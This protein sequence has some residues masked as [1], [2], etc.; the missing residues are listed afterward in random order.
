[1]RSIRNLQL[2]D[3]QGTIRMDKVNALSYDDMHQWTK[4]ILFAADPGGGG[5]HHDLPHGFLRRIYGQL[6]PNVRSVF[7]DTLRQHLV[8]MATNPESDWRGDAADELLLLVGAVFCNP[9]CSNKPIDFLLHMAEQDQ[10]RRSREPNLHRRTLQTLVAIQHGGKPG[11]WHRQY[12]HADNSY[13]RVVFAGLSLISTTVAMKWAAKE[14]PDT[15]VFGALIARLPWIVEH[16]KIKEV[17]RCM[18]R[19]KLLS[20]LTP[21]QHRDLLIAGD[22]LG[23]E[24]SNLFIGWTREEMIDFMTELRMPAHKPGVKTKTLRREL[25]TQLQELA[26]RS[27]RPLQNPTPHNEAIVGIAYQVEQNGLPLS[28]TFRDRLWPYVSWVVDSTHEE[29]DAEAD[30][31]TLLRAQATILATA[32]DFKKTWYG[33]LNGLPI[34]YLHAPVILSLDQTTREE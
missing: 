3:Q 27:D 11:F 31:L 29:P 16:Y 4:A 23:L 34:L 32:E 10:F 12:K 22:K 17:Q 1:M 7:E 13:A 14:L 5:H 25:Q 15:E 6:D 24:L 21:E 18:L 9:D 8:D 20:K 33:I 30:A 28:A 2:V 19:F 26:L